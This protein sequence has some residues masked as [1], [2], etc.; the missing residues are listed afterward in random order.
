MA[1][2]EVEALLMTYSRLELN[3]GG[4]SYPPRVTSST[5]ADVD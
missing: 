1:W 4:V 5:F 2:Y 3:L